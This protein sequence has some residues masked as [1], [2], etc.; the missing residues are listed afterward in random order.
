M[1]YKKTNLDQII[2]FKTPKLGPD[3]NSTAYIYI[4]I[5]ISLCLC[6]CLVP[7]FFT[8]ILK[9]G[10]MV[11]N[12]H[13]KS[14]TTSFSCAAAPAWTTFTCAAIPPLLFGKLLSWEKCSVSNNHVICADVICL[15][16]PMALHF[17]RF[18]GFF[19]GFLCSAWEEQILMLKW[20]ICPC[21]LGH[22]NWGRK[23]CQVLNSQEWVL[24]HIRRTA[25]ILFHRRIIEHNALQAIGFLSHVSRCWQVI[26]PTD[27]S[28]LSGAPVLDI[29][30]RYR[31]SYGL[32]PYVLEFGA[33]PL[34]KCKSCFSNRAS[35]KAIFQSLRCL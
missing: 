22:D 1:F 32:S 18:H 25:E 14:P 8:Y 35:V 19:P 2:T 23:T 24:Q 29:P 33:K 11:L 16:M 26:E 7:I 12:S 4:Y 27:T 21:F 28:K 34:W 9:P 13:R 31:Y 5:Y 15:R 6:L 30:W 10:K 20:Q 3:N 17:Q